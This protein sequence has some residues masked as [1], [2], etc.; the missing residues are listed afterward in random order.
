[1]THSAPAR[2]R[3]K[4]LGPILPPALDRAAF[5]TELVFDRALAARRQP[6]A[7]GGHEDD[8]D[9][10]VNLPPKEAN[11]GRGRPA[12][13]PFATAAPAQAIALS[14]PLEPGREATGLAL[15]VRR[16]ERT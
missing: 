13:A 11:R 16:V 4:A 14:R 8:C 10:D 6:L 1:P 3:R 2:K 12:P 5:H 7:H 15:V 9:R